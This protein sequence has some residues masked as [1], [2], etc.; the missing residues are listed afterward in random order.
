MI[1]LRWICGLDWS[2]ENNGHL[3]DN[4]DDMDNDDEDDFDDLHAP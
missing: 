2:H 4:M 1:P 3:Q